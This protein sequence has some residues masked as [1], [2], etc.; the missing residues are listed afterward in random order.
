MDEAYDLARR[1]ILE[2]IEEFERLAKGLL[3]YE[4]L[5]GDEI[6][7][8][9]AGEKIGDDDPPAK[10]PE[11]GGLTSIISIPKTKSKTPRA[12]PEPEPAV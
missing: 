5:T 3:E 8:V 10:P 1:T 9:M 7:R 6:R 4:T 11:E 2:N 12:G